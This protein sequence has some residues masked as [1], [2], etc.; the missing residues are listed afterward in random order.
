MNIV[1]FISENMDTI[2]NFSILLSCFFIYKSISKITQV[3]IKEK[4]NKNKNKDKLNK[5][6]KKIF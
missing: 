2:L 6:L 3:L 5:L 1:Q 4:D